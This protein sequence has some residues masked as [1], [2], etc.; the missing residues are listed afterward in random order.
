MKYENEY[1]K[2]KDRLDF[3]KICS[4]KYKDVKP[5]SIGRIYYKLKALDRK[6]EYKS[7]KI[8]V[9][10]DVIIKNG[11]KYPAKIVEIVKPVESV[12]YI[13]D[14]NKESEPSHQKLLELIDMVKFGEVL[15]KTT[16]RKYG[17]SMSEILWLKNRLRVI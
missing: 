8:E 10:D 9:K 16:L 17:F 14:E 12:V 13:D 2:A 5:E 6:E 7:D 1:K 3:I 4:K 11:N 15:T